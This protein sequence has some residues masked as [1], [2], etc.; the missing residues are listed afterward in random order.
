MHPKAVRHLSL[1]LAV[2]L[3]L[4]AISCSTG[5]QP[6]KPGTPAFYWLAAKETYAA[7]DYLKTAEHLEQLCRTQNEYTPRAQAWYLIMTSGMTK[8]YMELA[9][10]F[11]FGSRARRMSPTQFRRQMSDYRTYA[12][13]L[14]LQFAQVLL[15]FQ[16]NN[17]DQDIQLDFKAPVGSALPSPQI[18]KIGNGDLPTPAVMDDL[19]RQ[20]LQTG[21]LLATC[22]AV[23]HPEDSAKT[24]ELFRAGPVKV[25]RA[26]FLLAM[27]SAL[28]EQSEIFAHSK[29]DMPD[30]LKMYNASALDTLKM[31]PESE[32]TKKL[33]AK[34]QKSLKLASTK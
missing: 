29:L 34:I 2:G 4:V 11:E 23:G 31:V 8:S 19:R 20:H 27:A 9:D 26:T 7:G 22:R 1:F 21:V 3:G 13:R 33:A 6:P 17:K 30:R 32:Q 14:S 16:K 12:S 10:Y 15:D 5:P 28:Q 18:A 25:P 24:Q